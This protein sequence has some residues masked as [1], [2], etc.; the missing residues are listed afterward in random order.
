MYLRWEVSVGLFIGL[1]G[2]LIMWWLL[3][4]R[5]KQKYASSNVQLQSRNIHA[6]N[7]YS[8]ADPE[9]RRVYFG[10]DLF[11]YEELEKATNDFDRSRELGNGGFCTVYYGIPLTLPFLLTTIIK[12]PEKVN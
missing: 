10:V 12:L 11:S 8:N 7:P 9:S 1:L 3:E 6:N 4:R 5:C 2:I